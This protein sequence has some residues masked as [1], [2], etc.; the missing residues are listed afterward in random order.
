MSSFSFFNEELSDVE[1]LN[2]I[3]KNQLFSI[4]RIF[5][6]SVFLVS[7]ISKLISIDSFEIYVYSFGILNLDQAFLLSR[8]II[9]IELFLGIL[10]ISGKYTRIAVFTSIAML[11]VFSAFI[12]FL[13]LTK[14]KEHCHCFGEIELSHISSLIKNIFIIA[15]LLISYK[16]VDGKFKY[17]KLILISISVISLTIPLVI[18]PPDSFFYNMYAKDVTYNDIVL[19]EY[20]KENKQFNEGKK[21]LCFFSPGCGFCKLAARKVLIMAKKTNNPAVFNIVFAGSQA[22][23]DKFFKETDSDI[24]KYSFLPPNRFLKIT[25]GEMPLILLLDGGKVQ[26]KYAYR[27]INEKEIIRFILD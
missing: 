24:F 17:D 25:N 19:S 27:D 5:V 7:A 21:I 9:S 3:S 6:G 8:F 2:M 22:S 10:L 12:I 16:R 15:L 26:S 4:L 14:N 20:L 23:V 13:I 11:G 1:Y 18:S